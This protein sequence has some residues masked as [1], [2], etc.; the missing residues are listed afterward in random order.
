[1][2]ANFELIFPCIKEKDLAYVSTAIM[3]ISI[4]SITAQAWNEG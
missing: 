1:M 4:T 3:E 2:L